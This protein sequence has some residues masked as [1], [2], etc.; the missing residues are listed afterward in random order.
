MNFEMPSSA[1]ER[2]P[3]FLSLVEVQTKIE[4]LCGRETLKLERML[5]DEKGVYLY[6]VVAV[7]AEG[8]A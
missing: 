4:E 6:E 7:D 5:E 1:A 8:D 2:E 3:K